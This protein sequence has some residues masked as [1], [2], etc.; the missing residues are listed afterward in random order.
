ML[1]RH[2]S[3]TS[4][5]FDDFHFKSLQH[6]PEIVRLEPMGRGGFR[7]HTTGFLFDAAADCTAIVTLAQTGDF[8]FDTGPRSKLDLIIPTTSSFELEFGSSVRSLAAGAPAA[9]MPCRDARVRCTAGHHISLWLDRH[10]VAAAMRD[11]DCDTDPGDIP[12]A[13]FAETGLPGL[14]T[15]A[16][17][18]RQLIGI[19]DGPVEALIDLPAFRRAHEQL[20]QIRLAAVL[21][22]AME[23]GP[24]CASVPNRT[25]LS[26]AEDYIGA[27]ADREIDL[28]TLARH[29]GVSLRTLQMHV[30][31][32]F[33]CTIVQLIR[34]QRLAN[35]RWRLEQAEPDR[36]VA[37][38]ARESGFTHLGQFA[39]AYR[40][41]FGEQPR[42]TL[43]RARV[44]TARR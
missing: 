4:N 42:E 32:G 10:R 27:H 38:I 3:H 44:G 37:D 13:L 17:E 21:A 14:Q 30:R 34:R 20:L 43:F 1:D 23:A 15:L 26:R 6:I 35:A 16:L 7:S 8:S 24:R 11:L 41:T 28:A 22:Q 19:L 29:A 9:L 39:K 31:A 18:V 36:T 12:D 25:A 40:S 5:D 33:G 2:L